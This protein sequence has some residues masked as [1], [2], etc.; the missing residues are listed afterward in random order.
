[1]VPASVV[2]N[3]VGDRKYLPLCS[4]RD[5]D[6]HVNTEHVKLTLVVYPALLSPGGHRILWLVGQIIESDLEGD[7]PF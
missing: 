5:V 4:V 1:M 2:P 7:V 3:G 6:P